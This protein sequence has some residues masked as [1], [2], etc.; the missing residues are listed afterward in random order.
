MVALFT[1]AGNSAYAYSVSFLDVSLASLL[2][3]VAIPSEATPKYINP[4]SQTER[5]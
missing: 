5:I 1:T 4:D 3:A 2:C